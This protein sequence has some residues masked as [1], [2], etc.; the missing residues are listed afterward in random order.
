[1]DAADPAGA[2][3]NTSAASW[4]RR[5]AAPNVDADERSRAMDLFSKH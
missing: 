5:H 2:V 1:M 3:T 4:V